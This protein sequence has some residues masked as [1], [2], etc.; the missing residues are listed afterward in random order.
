MI[1]SSA[2]VAGKRRGFTLIELLVVIAIIALLAAI[3]FP[4]FSRVR[5][6]AR[7]TSCQNNLKQIGIAVEQYVQDYD[8]RMPN[9]YENEGGVTL[10]IWV[11]TLQPYTKSY[12]I[13]LC[14]S[15]KTP[16]SWAIKRPGGAP[17]PLLTAYGVN[18]VEGGSLNGIGAQP[19][20]RPW[21]Y[22]DNPP[23][24]GYISPKVSLFAEPSTTVSV[25][26]CKDLNMSFNVFNQTDTGLPANN[27]ADK[28][29]FDGLNILFL[30]GHV[31]WLLQ[32]E[33]NMWTIK[34]D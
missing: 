25:T 23:N 1:R 7:R 31:K 20:T 13:F 5:E 18:N 22:A 26:E 21:G 33:A 6:N 32:T 8:E 12:Q 4:V 34:A 10:Y 14:P 17:D 19:S 16:I 9:L 24:P 28:R 11:D 3:L 30:D 27:R 15:N 29:H 2:C